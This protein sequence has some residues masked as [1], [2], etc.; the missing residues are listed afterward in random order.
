[1]SAAKIIV[2]GR[3]LLINSVSI[4]FIITTVFIVPI[5]FSTDKQSFYE[6]RKVALHFYYIF[7]K[8]QLQEIQEF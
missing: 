6:S 4:F 2:N 1:M 5:L 7:I 3:K 8:Y